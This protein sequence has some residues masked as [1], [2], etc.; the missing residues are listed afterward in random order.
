MQASRS[1][2]RFPFPLPAGWFQLAW[3]EDLSPGQVKPVHYFGRQLAI[4]REEGGQIRVLDAICPHLGGHLG[5]G[6]VEGGQ[7]VCPVHGWKYA[8][9]GQCSHIP[10][11]NRIPR[12]AQVQSWPVVE[13]NGLIM[14]WF[15][16]DGRAPGW[17]LPELPEY[18]NSNWTPYQ[19]RSWKI[20]TCNQEVAEN[21]VDSAHFV[22]VHRFSQQPVTRAEAM[23]H[24]FRAVSEAV[25]ETAAGTAEGTISVELQGFGFAQTRFVGLVETLLIGAATPIDENSIELRFSFTANTGAMGLPPELAELFISEVVRTLEEDIPVWE[26]KA[27]L[28]RP[29]LCEN[30]GPIGM[31]RAWAQQFYGEKREAA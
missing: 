10:Y 19:K 12:Q 20:N 7:L 23:G 30:D 28:D 9:S 5:H 16:P 18:L 21:A 8:G 22:G 2:K 13:R 6:R 29:L 17:E 24:C 26:S 27:Y 31:F 11:T 3:S 15:A 4:F 1:S 25:L 14:V